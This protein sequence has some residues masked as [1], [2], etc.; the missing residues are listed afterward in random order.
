MTMT[1]HYASD[2][3]SHYTH[4]SDKCSTAS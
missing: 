2:F 3:Y 1:K 4:Y